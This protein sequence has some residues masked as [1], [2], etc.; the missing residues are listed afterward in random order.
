M[1]WFVW[2]LLLINVGVWVYTEYR[3]SLSVSEDVSEGR[4]PRVADLK[5]L[6]QE[7]PAPASGNGVEEERGVAA[8]Q[9]GR[10]PAAE[11]D[12]APKQ[13]RLP[14]ER[15]KNSAENSRPGPERRDDGAMALSSVSQRS[16]DSRV[17]VEVGWFEDRAG[18]RAAARSIP[19][20]PDNAEIFEISQ[21]LTAYHWVILPPFPSRELAAERFKE[22]QSEGIDSYLVRQGPKENAISLG[23]FRSRAA[24]EKVLEQRRSQGL[25]ARLASFPRNQIRYGLVFD[26][27]GES[28]QTDVKDT[29]ASSGHRFESVSLS[30]CE[31]VA[32]A[33]ETP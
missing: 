18:A 6:P 11:L 17:C 14:R 2:V 10:W 31:G 33:H 5:Q 13:E 28:G 22:L 26:A 19:A 32:T 1:K 25:N 30:E 29:L 21:P 20:V 15:Q 23:L 24:A 16:P 7:K 4:L 9:T 3:S 27:G 12:E 8:S